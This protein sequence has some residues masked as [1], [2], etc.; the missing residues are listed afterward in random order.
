MVLTGNLFVLVLRVLKVKEVILE[1]PNIALSQRPAWRKLAAE[2][3]GTGLAPTPGVLGNPA[4]DQEWKD[5]YDALQEFLLKGWPVLSSEVQLLWAHLQATGWA[6]L[7]LYFKTTIRGHWSVV[8]V[9]VS[10]ILT[11]IGLP[12]MSMFTYWT[13]D[14]LTYWDFM[15]RLLH[16]LRTR[17]A[18]KQAQ[19]AQPPQNS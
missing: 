1:R 8:L 6:L 10:L 3:L 9:A 13:M 7:A 19:A 12:V 16:E 15:G 11:S 4:E 14:R 2:V 17:E 5:W 18:V